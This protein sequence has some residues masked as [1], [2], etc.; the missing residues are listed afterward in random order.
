MATGLFPGASEI[1][2]SETIVI[3]TNGITTPAQLNFKK[4]RAGGSIS[5]NDYIGQISFLASGGGLTVTGAI[6]FTSTTVAITASAASATAL[7]LEASNAAGGVRIRAGTGG[8]TLGDEADT[9]PISIGDIA[10][11]ATRTITISGGTVVTAAVTDTLDLAPD[12]ATTNANSVK[13][14]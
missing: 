4:T 8:I 9:T 10:P 3:D 2:L 12:G 14:V 5:S 6:S 7:T 1:N 13:T 11:T